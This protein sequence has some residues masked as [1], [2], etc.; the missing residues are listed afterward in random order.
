MTFR[1]QGIFQIAAKL[2][3]DNMMSQLPIVEEHLQ[4]EIEQLTHSRPVTPEEL[5]KIR[6][7][8]ANR[9]IFASESPREKAGLYGYYDRV[10]GNLDV[11]LHY[12]EIVRS[13]TVDEIQAVA[14]QYLTPSAYSSITALPN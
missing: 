13:I 2:P 11:A 9:F 5:T 14:A 7:Q 4:L 8:V 6:T 12:P 10:V 1:W 3:A